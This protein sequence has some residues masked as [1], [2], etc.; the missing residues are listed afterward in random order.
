MNVIV[1]TGSDIGK[2]AVQLARIAGI[3]KIVA[4]SGPSNEQTLLK[5]GAIHIFDRHLSTVCP[6]QRTQVTFLIWAM[7]VS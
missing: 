2:V 1:S 6:S 3:D 7:S 5:L 4:V